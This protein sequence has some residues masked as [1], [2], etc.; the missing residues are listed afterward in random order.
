[1]PLRCILTS[2]LAFDA[3][4]NTSFWG[5]RRVEKGRVNVLLHLVHFAHFRFLNTSASSNW[6][7][8]R[9]VSFGLLPGEKLTRPHA[10]SLSWLATVEERGMGVEDRWAGLLRKG[11][12]GFGLGCG[13]N[14]YLNCSG[15]DRVVTGLNRLVN[16]RRQHL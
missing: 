3:L 13:F 9:S 14:S 15:S 12:T 8:H 5:G 6:S 4:K 10:T 7:P 1:M 2:S 11:R 16:R